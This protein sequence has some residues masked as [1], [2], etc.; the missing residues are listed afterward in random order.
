MSNL[1]KVASLLGCMSACERSWNVMLI[2][3]VLC[4]VLAFFYFEY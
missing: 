4:H 1:M 2:L 3:T